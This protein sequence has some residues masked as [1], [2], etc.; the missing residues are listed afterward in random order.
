MKLATKRELVDGLLHNARVAGGH[1]LEQRLADT[2][3][4]FSH[5]VDSIPR[6]NLAS[7]QAFL[8]K[9]FWCLLEICT[10]LLERSREE[11]GSKALYIPSGI[12]LEG[13]V[14]RYG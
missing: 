10:L 4:W 11:R 7:R 3:L 1:P 13:D 8:E 12:K 6:D 14:K 2:A 9:G 5:S